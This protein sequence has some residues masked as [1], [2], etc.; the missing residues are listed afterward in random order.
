M[1]G[2]ILI[3]I[4]GLLL[5]I[6]TYFAG[7]WR[8]EERLSKEERNSR[9]QRVFDPYMEFRRS[10]YTSGFDGLQ[11]AGVATLQ[12]DEEIPELI[13]LIGNHGETNPLGRN[14]AHL[15]ES[16]DLKKFFDYAAW[17][18]VNFFRTPIEEVIDKS[19]AKR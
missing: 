12:S 10:N 11:K 8:T 16:V 3:G 14:S 15:F 4:G 9:I 6:L 2:E 5:S 19:Q 13:E 17:G 7:V 18:H 1:M